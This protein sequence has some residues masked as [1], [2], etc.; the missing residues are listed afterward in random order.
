M[1]GWELINCEKNKTLEEI[2]KLADE[3][4]PNSYSANI[5]TRRK[6]CCSTRVK[7]CIISIF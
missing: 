7:R 2:I 1:A 6:P 5:K 4:N 3:L